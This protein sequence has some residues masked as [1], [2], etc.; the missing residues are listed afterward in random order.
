MDFIVILETAALKNSYV[1]ARTYELHRNRYAGRTASDHAD[2]SRQYF[3]IGEFVE[4]NEHWHGVRM[5]EYRI[6]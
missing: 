1:N 2:R 6:E 3:T 4:A 5:G